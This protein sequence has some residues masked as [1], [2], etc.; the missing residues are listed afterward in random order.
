MINYDTVSEAVNNLLQRGYDTSFNCKE[1]EQCEICNSISSGLSATDFVIDEVH[2]FE[3]MTDP[4]D[5]TIIYAVSSEIFNIKGI[6][7]N[8]YGMYADSDT[9]AIVQNLNQYKNNSIV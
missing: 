3:G 8:G 5:Q 4:A 2:R 7:V 1:S 9:S 6:V